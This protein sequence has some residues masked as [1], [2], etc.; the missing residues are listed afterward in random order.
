MHFA[1]TGS[2]GFIGSSLVEDL[3]LEGHK[4]TRVVRKT[5]DKL[6]DGTHQVVL[7][8]W[9]EIASMSDWSNQ[10]R[11]L[12]PI[13]CF[14]H[15]AGNARYGNGK[16]YVRDNVNLTRALVRAVEKLDPNPKFILA[17]SIG[18]VDYSKSSAL[19]QKSES[20][21]PHPR[22]DYGKSKLEA[23]QIVTQSS[24]R[25]IV[26]RIGMV[27]G[28]GMRAD[29]HLAVLERTSRNVF[30][31]RLLNLSPGLLPLVSITDLLS[32]IKL[33]AL[34]DRTGVFNVV[35]Q[36]VSIPEVVAA[37]NGETPR[38]ARR[39]SLG[40]VATRLPDRIAPILSPLLNFDSSKLRD[41]GWRPTSDYVACV[42]NFSRR[43]DGSRE[44]AIVTGC[45]SGLGL[46]VFRLLSRVGQSVV[47]IDR[48]ASRIREL[49]T[50]YPNQEFIVADTR[51]R[52]LFKKI[53]SK[54]TSQN[55]LFH[56]GDVYL[57]AGIGQRKR[58]L[59]TQSIEVSDLFD[60]N[61]FSRVRII[62]EFVNSHW[63]RG[64]AN[65][66]VLVGS[67]SALQPLTNFGAYSASNSALFA[68]ARVLMVEL[69]PEGARIQLVVPSGMST[70][71]QSTWGVKTP[72]RERLLDPNSVATVIW[73]AR[74]RKSGIL[75]VGTKTRAMMTMS[76]LLPIRFMDRI[77]AYLSYRLR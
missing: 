31:R 69:P 6:T 3:L 24:L 42:A 36:N 10:L 22:S 61:V 46:A 8:S 55:N 33:L 66:I 37:L 41:A 7:E 63:N 34:E 43:H 49:E 1:I 47:G 5:S 68:F 57:I 54:L 16:T 44:F 60:V 26:L 32:A 73:K 71:F 23:E 50:E 11:E 76:R 64:S 25:S 30:V 19:E 74:R 72:K 29:S 77:W 35:G 12:G 75:Y 20:A 70:S 59:D 56:I 14:V 65:R 13:D 28:H 9:P 40:R 15:L 18:A 53:I 48:D 4:V 62:R 45:C 21:I 67:S 2:S 38:H 58:I 27:F 17:S 52:D 39:P 51:D